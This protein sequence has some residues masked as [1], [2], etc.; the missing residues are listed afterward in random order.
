MLQER[1][2]DLACRLLI[3]LPERIIKLVPGC[4]GIE[5]SGLQQPNATIPMEADAF[6]VQQVI[7][8]FRKMDT[9]GQV[10]ACR[11]LGAEFLLE[12]RKLLAFLD[13]GVMQQGS[14]FP[15]SSARWKRYQSRTGGLDPLCASEADL[16]ELIC[17]RRGT[18]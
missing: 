5:F 13:A 9:L 18:N 12:T 15:A 16:D 8:N 4:P 14:A 17:C 3:A 7:P 1:I 6:L 10:G 2:D 11:R